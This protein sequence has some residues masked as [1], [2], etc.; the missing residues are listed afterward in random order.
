MSEGLGTSSALPPGSDL[1][2]SK[3]TTNGLLNPVFTTSC[4]VDDESRRIFEKAAR[5]MFYD[6]GSLRNPTHTSLELLD[7]AVKTGN[8]DALVLKGLAKENLE[9]TSK[10][11]KDAKWKGS[12]HPLLYS[13]LAKNYID[14]RR[15]NKAFEYIEKAIGGMYYNK[16]MC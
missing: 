5:S 16:C 11:F 3:C 2:E 12:K 6:D 13:A 7:Q 8:P 1:N 14:L 15:S 4:A 10:Y 9:D